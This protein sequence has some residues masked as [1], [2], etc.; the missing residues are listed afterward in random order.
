MSN[1]TAAEAQQLLHNK[2]VV[3]LGD[4]IQRSVYKDLVTFLQKNDYLTSSQLKAKGELSFERD[5]LVEGGQLGEL[6]NGTKYREVRQYRTDHHLIRFY[7]LT[8]VY[9]DYLE[10]ILADFKAGPQPDV[11]ITNSCLWDVSR[12]GNLSMDKY[13]ENL[14]KFFRRLDEVILPE[15]L[16]I[17][18]TAMPL[19]KKIT[20]GFL[21]P[22]LQYKDETLRVDVIEG[23]YY[24]ATLAGSHRFDVLDLHYYLRFDDQH[25]LKD[26]IHWNQIVHRKITQLLLTHIADA[27]GVEVPKEKPIVGSHNN[28]KRKDSLQW[29]NRHAVPYS[30]LAP[31]PSSYKGPVY[32]ENSVYGARRQYNGEPPFQMES[33]PLFFTSGPSTSYQ[34]GFPRGLPSNRVVSMMPNASSSS[35]LFN[36]SMKKS[37]R[38]PTYMAHPPTSQ[39]NQGDSRCS[40]VM[41]KPLQQRDGGPPHLRQYVLPYGR[42]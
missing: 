39:W 35:N 11:V 17:W 7:F 23:N 21:L 36:F 3:I 6:N 29:L 14:E 25:R 38:F 8:R 22:E 42:Y 27:W 28:E 18:N 41:R 15:C 19:A 26:G 9:S 40:L 1:F 2:F 20:G 33:R 31:Y 4:S 30:P 32:D 37:G 12:Y 24:S 10:S 34:C 5:S 13:R 16:F